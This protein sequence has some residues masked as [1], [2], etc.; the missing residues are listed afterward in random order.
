MWNVPLVRS[1]GLQFT[2]WSVRRS[3]RPH[4][5]ILPVPR[6]GPSDRN[7]IYERHPEHRSTRLQF[8]NKEEIQPEYQS[9]WYQYA[10]KLRCLRCSS[11][12]TK[13][14]IYTLLVLLKR[15]T[16]PFAETFFNVVLF[17]NV[18]LHFWAH[19]YD[20][21]SS[22]ITVATFLASSDTVA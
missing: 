13:N 4:V 15:L 20:S 1:F 14:N 18:I 6:S 16:H 3:A 11:V 22:T 9:G 10:S 7:V 2:R 8:Y 21:H 5:R 12:R 17:S 19:I